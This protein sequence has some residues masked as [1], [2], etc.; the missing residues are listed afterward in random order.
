M[1]AV[2]LTIFL[3]STTTVERRKYLFAVLKRLD[4][5]ILRVHGWWRE[6]APFRAALRART[7]IA[8][9]TPVLAVLNIVV[10]IGLVAHPNLLGEPDQLISWG[11]SFGPRTANGEWWRLFTSLF[12]HASVLDLLIT[13]AGHCRLIPLLGNHEEMLLLGVRNPVALK[14]WLACGGI[15]ALQSYGWTPDEPPR[16]ID[17]IL[18]IDVQAV[19]ALH[20]EGQLGAQGVD[21]ETPAEAAHRDLKGE[22]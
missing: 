9:V 21:I 10:A 2:A 22:R 7:P 4:L 6:L 8:P 12:V 19:E 20:G 3:R 11:A 15:E 13:L 1:L 14:S 17:E 18:A 5:F 16:P